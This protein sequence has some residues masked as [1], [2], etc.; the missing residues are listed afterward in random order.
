[1]NERLRITRGLKSLLF[2]CPLVAA[3][4]TRAATNPFVGEW[5]L[6]P[7]K[8]TLTDRMQV[9]ALADNK[10]T[11]DFGGGPET[12]VADGT[13]RPTALFKDGTLAVSFVGDSGSVIRKSNGRT[14]ISATWHLSGDGATLTDHFSSFN[15][16]GS[17]FTLNYVYARK[18]PGPGFAGTWVSTSLEAVNYIIQFQIQSNKDDGLSFVDPASQLTGNLQFAP[19]EIG[20]LDE[21]RLEL[22]RKTS[23]GEL[24]TVLR[25]ELSPD[26]GTLTMTP[27]SSSADEPHILVFDRRGS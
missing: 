19:S 1:M 25:L 18:A 5:R 10:Y 20:R 7:S 16:D 2:A 22:M 3:S 24:R 11:F 14:T 4:S 21:H 23:K 6:N 8:S 27:T 26:L 12:I 17:P 13:D 9:A 15:A